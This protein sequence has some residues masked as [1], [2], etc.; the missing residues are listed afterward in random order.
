[1]KENKAMAQEIWKISNLYPKMSKE[2]YHQVKFRKSIMSRTCFIK[3]LFLII[4]QY[5]QENT[6]LGVSFLIKLS[7]NKRP[8]TLSKRDS[9]TGVFCEY[10]QIFKNNYFEEH[11]WTAASESFS[12][13]QFYVSLNVFL[14]EQ[15]N[16][17]SYIG[18]EEDVFSKAKQKNH[19]KTQL[20]EKN[21]PFHDAL[22]HFFFL[23]FST[24]RQA[25]FVL[26]KDD[27]G[28]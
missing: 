23:C 9:N 17:T 10:C 21:L 12:L 27:K 16:I 28:W 4:L 24:A 18:G 13:Y 25:A 19:S 26:I 14:H 11:L 20:A 6:C 8:A 3:K 22:Y 1:M 2:F 15:N 7:F 5:S